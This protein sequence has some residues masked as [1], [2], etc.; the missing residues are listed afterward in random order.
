M[1]T[2]EH[3]FDA[4]SIV[5]VDDD[6]APIQEDVTVNIFD[7]CVVIEQ[8]CPSTG[9]LERIR[10]SMNQIKDLEAAFNLPEGTYLRAR[11]PET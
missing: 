7:D 4:T 10:L 2:I 3:G 8:V 9:K 5:L 11:E 6:A 1:F